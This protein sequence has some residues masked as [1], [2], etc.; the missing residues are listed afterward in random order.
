MT[1]ESFGPI[2]YPSP[3]MPT[4]LCLPVPQQNHTEL[5][6]YSLEDREQNYT[7]EVYLSN[8]HFTHAA[9]VWAEVPRL[10]TA[11]TQ[12]PPIHGQRAKQRACKTSALLPSSQKSA[13]HLP[14]AKTGRKEE[15]TYC[16][17]YGGQ[18][19]MATVFLKQLLRWCGFGN[20]S[21]GTAG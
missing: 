5:S 13:I 16:C 3:P 8:Y 6:V 12:R 17:Y 19:G 15:G 14:C 11:C 18:G 9:Q 2:V 7:Q 4:K 20:L 21:K 10:H 1:V